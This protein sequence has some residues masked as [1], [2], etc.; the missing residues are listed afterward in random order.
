MLIN[1]VQKE[2]LQHVLLNI[3]HECDRSIRLTLND[4]KVTRK[5]SKFEE[6][7]RLQLKYLKLLMS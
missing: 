6:L 3:Y 1:L 7:K 5:L 4:Y 2:S